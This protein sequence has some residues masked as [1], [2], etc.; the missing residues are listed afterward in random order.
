MARVGVLKTVGE[1]RQNLHRSE[2]LA[3]TGRRQRPDVAVPLRRLDAC[4][5]S[6]VSKMFAT[7][8]GASW[9]DRCNKW[10]LTHLPSGL[11]LY[12]QSGCGNRLAQ[13]PHGCPWLHY[14]GHAA[15]INMMLSLSL[16]LLWHDGGWYTQQPFRC[17]NPKK[18]GGLV[19]RE[20]AFGHNFRLETLLRQMTR[21][22]HFTFC[23]L[24]LHS[25]HDVV[26]L[27]ARGGRGTGACIGSD[28][29]LLGTTTTSTCSP[30]RRHLHWMAAVGLTYKG[31]L[32]LG[33]KQRWA[34]QARACKSSGIGLLGTSV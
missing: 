9:R 21:K 33:L 30:P 20:P 8:L 29:A 28:M 11:Y 25:P 16:S 17:L 2:G 13:L 15:D 22:C 31:D 1:L 19:V 14:A 26:V 12:S 4:L 32:G 10:D 24:R 6:H 27:S 5:C 7:A 3:G 23:F 34:D 18:G